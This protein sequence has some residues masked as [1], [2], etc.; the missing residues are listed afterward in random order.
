MLTRVE[1]VVGD[2]PPARLVRWYGPMRAAF[3]TLD[4]A[5]VPKAESTAW[6]IDLGEWGA[7]SLSFWEFDQLADERLETTAATI[8]FLVQPTANVGQALGVL[9]RCQRW[10]AR[11][12]RHSA[13]R[14]FD[15]VLRAHRFL[16]DLRK[17][18]LLADYRHALDTWQWVLRLDGEASGALQIAAL[19]HDIE[20]IASE[21]EVRVEHL[22]TN[23]ERFKNAHARRGSEI[24]RLFLR[25]VAISVSQA[26]RVADLV[27]CHETPSGD[28][29][30]AVL[31]DA[32]GLSF[33][34][35]NS[36]GFFDYYGPEH[37]ARKIRYTLAR[38]RKSAVAELATVRLRA[39]VDR[40][41]CQALSVA[42]AQQLVSP[43]P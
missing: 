36:A 22:A 42:D 37:T 13:G 30:L 17:P 32:D 34:S 24:T 38:M 39:D 5:I 25:D 16:Y 7:P 35:L 20:R 43:P 12:N 21:S 33:F 9:T 8:A 6:C 10:I 28:A 26:E 1:C 14:A 29:E 19:L 4:V 41:T 23:Y 31:N 15:C 11:R 18:L 2:T 3:P 40:L 27:A